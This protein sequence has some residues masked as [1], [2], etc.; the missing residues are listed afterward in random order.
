[1][2]RKRH[3]KPGDLAALRR[4]LWWTLRRV[5]AIC[6][7]EDAADVLVIK[8]AHALGQLSATYMRLIE[9]TELEPRLKALETLMQEKRP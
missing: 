1:M 8:A 6:D 2:A 5:E 9:V 7:D 3:G 4:T